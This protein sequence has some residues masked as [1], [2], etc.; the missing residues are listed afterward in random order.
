MLLGESP[1]TPTALDRYTVT[2]PGTQGGVNYYGGAFDPR[3]GLFVVNVNNLG[4]P[5]RIVRNPDGSYSNS[6]PLAGVVRFW[7]PANHLPCTPT[8]WGQL[9]AVDMNT[10]NIAWRSTL[11]VTD[12]L[13][14][15][16]QNTGRPGLG[17]AIVTASGLTFV[18][19]TDDA[20]FRA[21][22]TRTGKQL[23]VVKLPASAESTPITYADAQGRQYVAVV[24][25]GGF[26]VGA[27]LAG[28][29]LVVFSLHGQSTGTLQQA[30]PTSQPNEQASAA[31]ATETH[32]PP[33][34]GHDL[35]VRVC[36]G[37]HSPDLAATQ[38]LS[39]QEW[40]SLVQS[41]AARGAS[42]SDDEFDTI[43]DYL[44]KSFPRS[45]R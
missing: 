38:R 6:G 5:M 42:A 15:G 24:A 16:K 35:T 14:P 4:Q 10:G 36:S 9:V 37:C 34:P 44:A 7:N 8:P 12:S 41:M 32:L 29:A 23:W 2:L 21:F 20:R 3:L 43:T 30:Q 31:P 18:G 27:A 28:D 19:A 25:T 1:Y 22:D 45:S 39:P 40:N 11:G 17:G 26:G 33:G 13:P